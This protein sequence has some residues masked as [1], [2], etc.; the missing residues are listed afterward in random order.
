MV[1]SVVIS[2]FSQILLK[3]GANKKY[4]SFRSEYLNR[5]VIGGY[6]LL[7]IST[8]LTIWA[9]T[10]IAYT[11]GPIIESLAYLFVMLLSFLILKEKISWNIIVGNVI[12]ITGLVIFYI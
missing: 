3:I 8:L 12:I 9:Y 11:S 5:Y 1:I 4:T 7:F 6:F 2:S 10:G